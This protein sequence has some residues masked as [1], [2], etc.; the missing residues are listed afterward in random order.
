MI[1]FYNFPEAAKYEFNTKSLDMSY[2]ISLSIE[3][4]SG[5]L[6]IIHN[7]GQ[8]HGP[9]YTLNP[10][11]LHALL[12]HLTLN[13]PPQTPIKPTPPALNL[14]PGGLTHTQNSIIP[15][16]TTILRR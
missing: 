16:Q 9:A 14:P 12:F 11:S 7:S 3:G 10:P 8:N 4:G 1:D 15:R 13:C 2:P 6:P 5:A